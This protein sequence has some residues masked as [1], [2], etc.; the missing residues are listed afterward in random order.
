MQKAV[1]K[2]IAIQMA[3]L[4]EFIKAEMLMKV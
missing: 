2:E 3:D 1:R 4:K